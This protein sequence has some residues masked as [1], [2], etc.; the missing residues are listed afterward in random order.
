MAHDLLSEANAEQ[1]PLR[2]SELAA[3]Q[4]HPL[5]ESRSLR[6]RGAGVS[7]LARAQVYPDR[8]DSRP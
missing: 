1:C 2:R 3:A 7:T 8:L 6:S 4:I 5:L